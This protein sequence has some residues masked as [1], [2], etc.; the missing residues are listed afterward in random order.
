[1]CLTVDGQYLVS[2]D[3]SGVLYVWST[4]HIQAQDDNQSGLVSTF[5]IHKDKGPITN[6]V[7]LHRPLSLFGL[8]ANMKAYETP[9]INPL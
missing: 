5:E 8:T 9:E 2:G 1:M 4:A 6:I 3:Q 7:A